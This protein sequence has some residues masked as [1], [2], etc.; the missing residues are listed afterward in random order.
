L[1]NAIQTGSDFQG[2]IVLLPVGRRWCATSE[3]RSSRYLTL[4]FT[5]QA[6]LTDIAYTVQVSSDLQNWQSG[7]SYAVRT[8]NGTTSTAVFRDLT[9]IGSAPQ[10]FMRLSVTRQ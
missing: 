7:A 1:G 10:R 4:T 3:R 9:A 2:E 6:A 8:D 5:D